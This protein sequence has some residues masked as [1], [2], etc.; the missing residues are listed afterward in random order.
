MS[1]KSAGKFVRGNA[2]L[3]GLLSDVARSDRVA[4]I[5][6]SMDRADREH[7]MG[8][9]MVRKVANLTQQELAESLGI[10]QVAVQRSEQRND[11]LL[12]TLRRYLQAAGAELELTIRWPDGHHVDLV[13]DDLDDRSPLHRPG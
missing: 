10:S 5:S 1:E 12:S 3:E 13:L 6:E 7:A 8:L 11:M 2:R 9:A 4:E